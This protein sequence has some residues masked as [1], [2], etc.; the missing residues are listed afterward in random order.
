MRSLMQPWS[1]GHSSLR[2]AG[3]DDVGQAIVPVDD[4]P[5]G[6]AQKDPGQSRVLGIDITR[7]GFEWAVL[8]SGPSDA[9]QTMGRADARRLMSESPVRSPT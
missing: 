7:Q 8:H 1:T 5:L 2:F 9:A 4:V 3:S 6:W